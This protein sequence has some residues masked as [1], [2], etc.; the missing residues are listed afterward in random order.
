M[1]ARP[2]RACAV[3]A[4]EPH[5]I[6]GKIRTAAAAAILRSCHSA[7]RAPR[8]IPGE[9]RGAAPQRLL[10]RCEGAA[11][12]T[13]RPARSG[14]RRAPSTLPW[15]LGAPLRSAPRRERSPRWG[16]GAEAGAARAAASG[17]PGGQRGGGNPR[18]EPARSPRWAGGTGRLV[19]AAGARH[20]AARERDTA[21]ARER[22]PAHRAPARPALSGGPESA[23]PA[24]PLS[25]RCIIHVPE[26]RG[27]AGY[28]VVDMWQSGRA[29]WVRRCGRIIRNYFINKCCGASVA[30]YCFRQM[31]VFKSP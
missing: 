29:S 10:P 28:T 5:L 22:D 25:L 18:R 27:S 3:R 11:G 26:R 23:P 21:S 7:R 2:R 1:P 15:G 16:G 19:A 24:C 31:R 9:Q 17:A 4:Q 12:E 6:G 13:H 20:R 30:V 8:R 14:E